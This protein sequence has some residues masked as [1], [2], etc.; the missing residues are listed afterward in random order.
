MI[1]RRTLTLLVLVVLL[2]GSPA[3]AQGSQE[4]LDEALLGEMIEAFVRNRAEGTVRSVS[5][6]TLEHFAVSGVGDFDVEMSAHPEQ[7]MAGWV[8]VTLSVSS[9]GETLRRGVVTVRVDAERSVLVTR[10]ALRRGA[11]LAASDLIVEPRP[12]SDLP[13]AWLAESGPATGKRLKR[14]LAAGAPVSADHLEQPPA[15]RRGE[16]VKLR[17]HHGKLRI[18][19]FGRAQQDGHAGEWIRV[20]NL[21]SNR[22]VMGRVSEDGVI[23]VDL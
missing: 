14:S 17:L 23:R 21:S 4:A 3:V 2:T 5:I 9:G 22:E 13:D 8:P 20:R 1:P 19:G 11:I 15:V 10:R 6:P 16:R 12:V 18:D 7:A